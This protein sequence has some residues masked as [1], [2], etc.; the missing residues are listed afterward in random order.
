ME[1]DWMLLSV[2]EDRTLPL[3]T[4]EL[5][6]LVVSTGDCY[7]MDTTKALG[8]ENPKDCHKGTEA[9][10]ALKPS[11]HG[12]PWTN[13]MKVSLL[14]WVKEGLTRQEIANKYHRTSY[15]IYCQLKAM[16][17]NIASTT[18]LGEASKITGI[19]VDAIISELPVYMERQKQKDVTSKP[20]PKPKVDYSTRLNQLETKID[21]LITLVVERVKTT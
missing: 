2:N 18:S 9:L 16:A 8:S 4:A 15:S 14:K 19:P 13:D 21:Y 12:K 6:D 1:D 11:N 7:H 20:P 17:I 10:G 3:L 5:Q